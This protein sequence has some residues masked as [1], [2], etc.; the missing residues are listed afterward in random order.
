MHG[1]GWPNAIQDTADPD[2]I[3][4]YLRTAIRSIRAPD[5]ST[6]LKDM[7]TRI[8]RLKGWGIQTGLACVQ[9]A[10][11]WTPAVASQVKEIVLLAHIMH[12]EDRRRFEKKH[13][14]S[15]RHLTLRGFTACLT[16]R[17]KPHAERELR[18]ALAHHMT[19]HTPQPSERPHGNPQNRGNNT[20]RP[21][22]HSKS[23]D[24]S[25]AG[26]SFGYLSHGNNWICQWCAKPFDGKLQARP[27]PKS[28]SKWCTG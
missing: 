9:G 6:A 19:I 1:K 28:P 20:P 12:T 2:N 22:P 26:R 24:V 7:G 17:A 3:L 13:R 14:P 21:D 23:A 10:P 4:K 5:R 18:K 11:C 16:N 8:P 25:A 15:C 27:P